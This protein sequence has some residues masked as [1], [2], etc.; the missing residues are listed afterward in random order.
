MFVKIT[1]KIVF[2][3]LFLF[4]VSDGF[5][6]Q[7]SGVEQELKGFDLFVERQ[8]STD[9]IPGLSIGFIK[10]GQI[11]AKGYG[12]ADLENKAPA[13]KNSM[14][15]LASITKPMTAT[16]ILQL[17]EKGKI[18]LDAEVQTYV[19]YF[20]KKK[21]PVTVR[22]L[23]GHLAG[24][25]HYRNYDLEGHF[26]SHKDTREAIRVFENFELVAKPGERFNYSSYGYNLLGAVIEGASGDP[27][28][29]YMKNNVWGPLGMTDIR[30]DDPEDLIPNR[31]RGYQIVGGKL[32]NSEFVDIS[33][34]FAAGGTRASIIDVLKFGKGTIDGKV[35]SNSSLE[36]MRNSMITSNGAITNYSAGWGTYPVNGRFVLSH[37]GGQAETS[38]LLYCFPSRDLVI[39]ITTNLE[40][41][42][43]IPYISRLFEMLTGESWNLD[44]YIAD[45]SKMELFSSL[46]SAFEEG[47]S[48]FEKTGK[49]AVADAET[50]RAFAEFNQLF[51]DKI[52]ESKRSANKAQ[53]AADNRSRTMLL[54]I[55][56]HIAIV[57]HK[58]HGPTGLNRYSNKGAIT[59]FSHYIDAYRDDSSIPKKFQLADSIVHQIETWQ[60]SW[61]KTNDGSLRKMVVG[62]ELEIA[63]L[64]DQMRKAFTGKDVYPDFSDQLI[65]AIR[66]SD[67]KRD[68]AR[69]VQIGILAA[70]LYPNLSV[71]NATYGS[72]LVAF[73]QKR[74]GQDY[75]RRAL[76][77]DP[78][79]EASA[80]DLNSLAFYLK[81]LGSI[82]AGVLILQSAIELHPAVANLYDSLG[83][84]YLEK[85]DKAKALMMYKAA[86]KTDP[87]YS[88][89]TQA[90]MIVRSLEQN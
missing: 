15:R 65:E 47:R 50:S 43:R 71:T 20:P 34:R 79:G 58:K 73:G 21:Y 75:L 59:F 36:L 74:A 11:W 76:R 5:G 81:G 84:F 72:L 39:A 54:K 56:S 82:D 7:S 25:S 49:A 42:R 57:L 40:G 83:E 67:L 1:L 9:K 32:K 87:A 61:E 8:M 3:V 80:R 77:L 23:L 30:M 2:L 13:T 4:P 14:Y 35:L 52:S 86:L 26:K 37:S 22:K 64:D 29:E 19:P 6:Q 24:I 89:S 10:G 38:T 45:S 66:S 90:Q 41:A 53:L 44:V 12:F 28:A 55:G 27:Y 33:S 16:A 18:D 68:T 51:D 46:Q 63:T 31:V 88:N 48:H 85:G 69:A 70:D 17:V 78:E 62:N 60:T